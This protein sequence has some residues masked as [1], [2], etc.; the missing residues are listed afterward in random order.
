MMLKLPVAWNFT[1]QNILIKKHLIEIVVKKMDHL[2][3]FEI[4]EAMTAGMRPKS[5]AVTNVV[6]RAAPSTV[7]SRPI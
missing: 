6:T 4:Q 5:S 1:N 7:V 2:V 3:L